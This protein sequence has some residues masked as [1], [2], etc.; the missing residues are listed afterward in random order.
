MVHFQTSTYAIVGSGQVN[1]DEEK[2]KKKHFGHE[3]FQSCCFCFGCIQL[4]FAASTFIIGEPDAPRTEKAGI[5]E[6]RLCT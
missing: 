1:Q 3:F 6:C 4:V 5:Q 2:K